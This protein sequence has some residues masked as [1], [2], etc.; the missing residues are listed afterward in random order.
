[1]QVSGDACLKSQRCERWVQEEKRVLGWSDVF[2]RTRLL[3]MAAALYPRLPRGARLILPP[4]GAGFAATAKADQG[5]CPTSCGIWPIQTQNMLFWQGN[6]QKARSSSF[7]FSGCVE[8]ERAEQGLGI[9][10]GGRHH[11]QHR[12]GQPGSWTAQTRDPLP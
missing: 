5:S 12:Q 9:Q 4:L 6:M 1:M 3:A 10:L 8:D 2:R 11:S 7:L